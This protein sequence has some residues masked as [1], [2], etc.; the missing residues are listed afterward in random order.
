MQLQEMVRKGQDSC[1]QQQGQVLVSDYE[2][3][4]VVIAYSVCS[5]FIMLIGCSQK[6]I[7]VLF[8]LFPDCVLIVTTGNRTLGQ[9]DPWFKL[10]FNSPL[11]TY[12]LKG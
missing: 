4:T 10:V 1:F 12:V 9:I 8:L 5:M 6:N 3:V 7:L 2:N 11:Q